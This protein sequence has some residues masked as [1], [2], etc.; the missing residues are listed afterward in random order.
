MKELER[1]GIVDRHVHAGPPVRVTYG[2]TDMGDALGPALVE[3]KSWAQA[4]LAGPAVDAD[5]TGGRRGI[6]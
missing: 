5:R 1:R 3:L 6:D 2:L 4:W